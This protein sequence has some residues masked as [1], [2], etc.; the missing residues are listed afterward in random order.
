M[1][2]LEE[3][4]G[5]GPAIA[6]KLEEAGY[7]DLM[8]IAVASPSELAEAIDIGEGTALKIIQAAREKADVGGDNEKAE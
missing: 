7:D 6:R 2:D 5:V 3:L 8:A 4:P 1:V